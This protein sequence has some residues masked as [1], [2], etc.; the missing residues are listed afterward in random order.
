MGG[1]T[2]FPSLREQNILQV[3]ENKVL[4]K[5]FKPSLKLPSIFA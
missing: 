1:K 3:I 4:W 5:V 2:V